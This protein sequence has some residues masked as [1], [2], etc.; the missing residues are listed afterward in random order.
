MIHEHWRNDPEGAADALILRSL[1]D[2]EVRGRVLLAYRV[3][4]CRRC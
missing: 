1:D 2:I 4:R 3:G